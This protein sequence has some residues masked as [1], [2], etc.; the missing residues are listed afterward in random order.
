MCIRDSWS[1]SS[2]APQGKLELWIE[3]LSPP[4][5]LAIKPKM[6]TPPQPLQGELRVVVWAIR[7]LVIGG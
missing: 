4:Q 3:I 2:N 1:P 5:A 6:L 7:E